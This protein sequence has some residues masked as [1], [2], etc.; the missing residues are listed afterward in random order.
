MTSNITEYD[1]MHCSLESK[2]HLIFQLW[3]V[4]VILFFSHSVKLLASI[5]E[6]EGASG[7]EEKYNP[8]KSWEI[9]DKVTVK[10]RKNDFLTLY[11]KETMRSANSYFSLL[12]DRYSV[13]AVKY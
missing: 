8:H 3:D 13:W 11:V 4:M 12:T 1:I 7:K 10:E 2:N 5:I 9:M 6:R